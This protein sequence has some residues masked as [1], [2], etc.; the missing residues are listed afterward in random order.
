MRRDGE[1]GKHN[2]G[3]VNP[4]LGSNGFLERSDKGRTM[5]TYPLKRIPDRYLVTQLQCYNMRH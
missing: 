3:V 4:A 2:C 5:A 1:D